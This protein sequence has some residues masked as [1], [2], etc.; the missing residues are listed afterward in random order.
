MSMKFFQ[1]L[2]DVQ[3]LAY[4]RFVSK[5]SNNSLILIISCIV[6]ER[7]K[8]LCLIFDFTSGLFLDGVSYYVE[9]SPLICSAN[10]WTG[11]YMIRTSV[12]KELSTE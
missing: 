9:T 2:T 7:L 4:P 12:M 10:Q 6:E 8:L 5:I 3:L 1:I 11:F